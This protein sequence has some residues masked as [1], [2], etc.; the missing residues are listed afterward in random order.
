MKTKTLL[1]V[2]SLI[3]LMIKAQVGYINTIAGTGNA[4]Y[5]GD[6]GQAI[7]AELNIPFGMVFDAAGNLYFADEAN[8]VIRKIITSTGVITTY[9]GTYYPTGGNWYYGGDGGPADS[10][11]LANPLGIALD[12]VGNI[13]FADNANNVIRKITVSTGIISTVAGNMMNIMGIY[14]FAGDGGLAT[15]AELNSPWGVA[16]DASG[17]IYIADQGFNVIRKVTVATGII[18]TVVGDG[19]AGYSGDGGLAA[20]AELNAPDGITIDADGNIY[21]SDDGNNVIRKID[22]TSGIITTIVGN[23]IAGSSGDGGL[24]TAAKLNDP[25]LGVAIDANGNIYIADDGNNKIRK[26]TKSTG[27]ISTIA[28]TGANGYSGDGGPATLAKF[29]G[30]EGVALDAAGNIYISDE[31][32]VIRKINAATGTAPATPG[33]ITGS[34]SVCLGTTNTYSIISVSGATSYTWTLPIGWTGTST[35]N[36]INATAGATAGTISVTANNSFGSSSPQTLNVTVNT[37][38]TSVSQAGSTLTANANGTGYVWINCSG[39]LPVSG[40]TAQSFTATTTG[41]YAVIV[42]QSGC[43]DTS[44]CYPV[45]IS[46]SAPATPIAILGSFTVCHES[47]NTYS[48]T[49]VIGAT[50]YTWTLPNGWSGTSSTDSINA[51][52]GLSGT[53]SVTA[54]N[55]YGSSSPQTINVTVITVNTS[56]TQNGSMLTANASG[57]AYEWLNCNGNILVQGETAQSFTATSTGSYAVIVTQNG[58][59][60]TSSCYSTDLTCNI[61]ITGADMPYSSLSVM[62]VEDTLPNISLGG[63][64]VAQTWNYSSLGLSYYKFAVYNST[65]TTPY[66]TTFPTSN[67]YTYGPGSM[68]GTLYGGAPVGSNDNGYVFWKSDNTGFWITGFRPDGGICAGKNVHDV[69]QELLIGAPATY[70]SVFNNSARWVLPMNNNPSD[71]DT[72][73]VR[74][75]TKVITADAC[76]SLTTP[77]GSYPS[78]LRQHEYVITVD[79]I[80]GKYGNYTVYSMEYKRDTLNNYTYISNGLGY[81]PCIVHADKNNNIKDVEYFSGTFVGINDKAVAD[82][83]FSVY[84]NPSD[85]NFTIE[86]PQSKTNAENQI[87]IYNAV[88]GLIWQRSTFESVVNVDI[89]SFAKGI[90]V[91]K[92]FNSENNYSEKIVVQ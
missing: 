4:D 5:S 11:Y 44:A 43:V 69:P 84:P 6:S 64:G 80:Y 65:S 26:V 42:S 23:G 72:F 50:S 57:A 79:S 56:V 67:I 14:A 73:Y 1:I 52:A 53:I 12:A 90:Y 85:G 24:A 18:T 16:I 88:G 74:T 34:T 91:V 9:A 21:I 46:G 87:S 38:N 32:N 89:Q 70:G 63:S 20:N 66:A 82:T 37:V 77:Y 31:N 71:V 13:Y 51:T 68:Y 36:T 7:S 41:N 25:S 61:T 62:L 58:C 22:A 78:V 86:I 45:N 17:N 47:T 59:A 83:K 27:I 28:G 76:G 75:L 48:V 3:S 10:A 60:D 92:I 30:P 19:N 35:T 54:N 81:P 49:P 55:S 2:F 8:N 39:N 40:Q 33:V 29:D 15:D